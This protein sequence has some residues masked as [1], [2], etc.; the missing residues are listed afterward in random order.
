MAGYAHRRSGG[1]LLL[2]GIIGIAIA[3]METPAGVS[4]ARRPS[5]IRYRSWH[6][7]H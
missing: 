5:R 7:D 3:L 6:E 4:N 1:A 2:V